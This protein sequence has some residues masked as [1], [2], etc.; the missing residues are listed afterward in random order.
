M[1]LNFLTIVPE[2]LHSFGV[3]IEFNSPTQQ[4]M[5]G[6]IKKLKLPASVTYD[7]SA[8]TPAVIELLTNMLVT[9]D[10]KLFETNSSVR[11][12]ELVTEILNI[13]S[14]KEHFKDF[15]KILSF[16]E[17]SGEPATSTTAGIHFH[18]DFPRSLTACQNFVTVS[19]HLE[20]L[21]FTIGGFGYPHRALS[22]DAIYYRP[23][24][25]SG[26]IV[27][28]VE[29]GWA[30]CFSVES[31]QKASSMDEFF[32]RYGDANG[33]PGRERH[34]VVRY[35]FINL[36][37]MVK[38]QQTA[39]IRVFNTTL[40]PLKLWSMLNFYLQMCRYVATKTP[41]EIVKDGLSEPI[42]VFETSPEPVLNTLIRAMNA[43]GITESSTIR[44]LANLATV[45]K[46]V[47]LEERLVRSHLHDRQAVVVHW[48]QFEKIPEPLIEEQ[49]IH[50]PLYVDSYVAEGTLNPQTKWKSL[51]A[52]RSSTVRN[53]REIVKPIVEYEYPTGYTRKEKKENNSPELEYI[54]MYNSAEAT[55]SSGLY[56][57][58]DDTEEDYYEEDE[59]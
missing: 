33:G 35:H 46:E 44:L 49:K 23:I 36:L 5:S 15:I 6:T 30:Q 45:S 41:A 21:F 31:L 57:E 19:A 27:V 59:D 42:S 2:L 26:P 52:M 16:L 39:E 54:R 10:T 47:T 14:K 51:E 9:G 40:D 32:Q 1:S 4:D 29:G 50:H 8:Q 3:E 25:K 17:S 53:R 20:K 12:G 13:R 11:G 37:N 56:S 48:E 43:F 22:G 34:P 38:K 28:P 7:V 18:V 55:T 24:T 58:P